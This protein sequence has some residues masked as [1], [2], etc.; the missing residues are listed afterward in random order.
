M[1]RG[2]GSSSTGQADPRTRDER[3]AAREEFARK[4]M[5]ILAACS[6]AIDDDAMRYQFIRTVTGEERGFGLAFRF[7][8]SLGFGGKFHLHSRDFNYDHRLG[9]FDHRCYVSCY[10]EDR[11]P[12]REAL[13]RETNARLSQL[14][15]EYVA[16]FKQR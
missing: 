11:T 3:L 4:A 13:I 9:D 6:F 14:A 10:P 8:G 12:Q 2:S 7:C 16:A 15:D 1:G 5:E